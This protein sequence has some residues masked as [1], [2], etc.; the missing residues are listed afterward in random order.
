[1][2]TIYKTQ[3]AD[4]KAIVF[5]LYRAPHQVSN[6]ILF[7]PSFTHDD[8]MTSRSRHT[9]E[10][11]NPSQQ[12]VVTDLRDNMVQYNPDSTCPSVPRVKDVLSNLS[13]SSMV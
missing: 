1:M 13:C 12:N 7:H 3:M 9:Y 2:R 5:I 8:N 6:Y 10:L 4:F 11:A